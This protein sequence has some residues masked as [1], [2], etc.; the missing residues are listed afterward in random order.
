MNKKQIVIGIL[1]FPIIFLL[2]SCG[3]LDTQIQQAIAETQAAWTPVPTFTPYPTFTPLPIPPTSTPI[4]NQKI[5]DEVIGTHWK[6]KVIKAEGATEYE[7]WS[8]PS[9]SQNHMVIL[10]VE[11]TYLGSEDINFYPESAVLAYVETEGFTG[12]SRTPRLYRGENSGITDFDTSAT[13]MYVRSGDTFTDI[14]IYEFP[15]DYKNFIFYFPE[16]LPIEVQI[17]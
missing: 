4:S 1:Y 2:N 10:T 11:Y 3:I 17:K 13:T 12:W 6:V 7:T 8:F 14:F 5:G 9:G 16:T 15:I